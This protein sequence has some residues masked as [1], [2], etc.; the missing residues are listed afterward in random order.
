MAD[1]T[2]DDPLG[3][4][5]PLKE[6]P[7]PT[8]PDAP[9]LPNYNAYMSSP[10][11]GRTRADRQAAYDKEVATQTQIWNGQKQT[12]KEANDYNA[13]LPDLNTKGFQAWQAR[14]NQQGS[15][16]RASYD[17]T[18]RGQIFNALHDFGP[19]AVGAGA[20]YGLSRGVNALDEG[21]IDRQAQS[22]KGAAD[23]VRG[24]AWNDPVTRDQLTGAVDTGE[25]YM[26]AERPVLN[27]LGRKSIGY[28]IPMA[29]ALYEMTNYRGQ[30]H[31]QS[32][33]PDQR[34]NARMISNG[35][36]AGAGEMGFHGG[37]TAAFPYQADT[38]ADEATIRAARGALSANNQPPP[39]PPPIGSSGDTNTAATNELGRS[40]G[41]NAGRTKGATLNAVDAAIGNLPD[42]TIRNTAGRIHAYDPA[43]LG[44]FN[45]QTATAGEL[46][47]AV[48]NF[49]RGLRGGGNLPAILA[50]LGLGGLAATLGGSDSAEAYEYKSGDNALAPIKAQVNALGQGLPSVGEIPGK[51]WEGAKGVARGI[52]GFARELPGMVANDAKD[53]MASYG[54]GALGLS[55][56][57]ANAAEIAKAFN[58]NRADYAAPKA[59]INWNDATGGVNTPT[60]VKAGLPRA[61]IGADAQ[62]PIDYLAL[63]K[64]LHST[65]RPDYQAALRELIE[66]HGG[67]L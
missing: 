41:V 9:N 34:E 20:G 66:S 32:I 37:L 31:D 45:P 33:S 17:A 50:A 25:R 1:N 53:A 47:G 21:V 48:A 43:A 67:T 15:D 27:S 14:K 60:R 18:L 5:V 11:Y 42:A 12:A 57:Q 39:P 40:V 35:L 55:P 29:A 44:G 3:P 16:N 23:Q 30:S 19:Y 65:Q 28:G 54:Q 62:G 49:A 38:G 63:D 64:M 24:M 10:K 46:R 22:L 56:E 36:M 13:S 52:P 8:V 51:L 6:K 59:G 26:P 58:E 7:L 4:Y 2:P 61:A